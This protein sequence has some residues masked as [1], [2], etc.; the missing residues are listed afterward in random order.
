MTLKKTRKNKRLLGGDNEILKGKIFELFKENKKLHV[1]ELAKNKK[2]NYVLSA[3]KQY[4]KYIPKRVKKYIASQYGIKTDGD[5]NVS[6]LATD[7]DTTLK[8][9][10]DDKNDE[11]LFDSFYD[12]HKS[13]IENL[14]EKY[15]KDGKIENS[16]ISKIF[17]KESDF[18]KMYD[19]AFDKVESAADKGKLKTSKK[20]INEVKNNEQI[21]NILKEN[22]QQIDIDIPKEPLKSLFDEVK[23]KEKKEGK[24]KEI[25]KDD[26]KVEQV[27]EI[28]KDKEDEE[29][30]EIKGK[31]ELKRKY[32]GNDSILNKIVNSKENIKGPLFSKNLYDE[33]YATKDKP[34][35]LIQD[36]NQIKKEFNLSKNKIK[37]LED[38]IDKYSKLEVEQQSAKIEYAKFKEEKAMNN[39]I[40]MRDI[41]NM[42]GNV[43][44]NLGHAT[45]YTI[46]TARD[47][48]STIGSVGQGV[49]IKL[50]FLILIIIAIIVGI[51][52]YNDVQNANS[53]S[54]MNNNN[55]FL[56]FNGSNNFF[57]NINE[58]IGG[59]LPFSA[60]NGL[61]NSITFAMTG[62]NIYDKYLINREETT[63]GRSDNIFH[64]NYK[65]NYGDITDNEKTYCTIK[66]KDIIINYNDNN[67]PNSDYNKLDDDLK[68]D[69]NY[70]KYYHIP[71]VSNNTGKYE[72]DLKN[73]TFNNTP[74]K[75]ENIAIR[76]SLSKYNLF[77]YNNNNLVLNKFNNVYYDSKNTNTITNI[78]SVNTID[79]YSSYGIYLVN[80]NYNGINI[81]IID[82]NFKYENFN[83]TAL[84]KFDFYINNNDFNKN[85]FYVKINKKNPNYIYITSRENDENNDTSIFDF[86]DI[87]D[88]N[89]F[90]IIKLYNQ[91]EKLSVHDLYFKIPPNNNH[92]MP[93]K[94]K[95]DNENQRF[96]ID[97]IV[98]GDNSSYLY[99]D[100]AINGSINPIYEIN[101]D[102]NKLNFEDNTNCDNYFLLYPSL[103]DDILFK[104]DVTDHEL[105]DIIL[106]FQN[107]QGEQINY[108]YG[109][110]TGTKRP[111]IIRHN[112]GYINL[113]LNYLSN[114][115]YFKDTNDKMNKYIK[116]VMEKYDRNKNI[117]SDKTFISY[118]FLLYFIM[119]YFSRCQ[120][121]IN[122][123]DYNYS[124]DTKYTRLS[125][126]IYLISNNEDGGNT[127]IFGP[128]TGLGGSD[129]G[130]WTSNK[131]FRIDMTKY[132]N[133]KINS[134]FFKNKSVQSIG[135]S[136]INFKNNTQIYK[137][138]NDNKEY[139]HKELM[140]SGND[141]K[142]HLLEKNLYFREPKSFVGKLYTL[143]INKY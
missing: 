98:D 137:Y 65:N 3:A 77:K 87:Y 66:P 134:K 93:P 62:Q 28:K 90:S 138:F 136:S 52:K 143:I 19:V 59:I 43:L 127:D 69:M 108:I 117:N 9:L 60:L 12:I 45:G 114:N 68:K 85:I 71:I 105:S 128:K 95:Y 58:Y 7:I 67:Y 26:D 20:T 97:F 103:D 38:Q 112:I 24:Q 133:I 46:S 63:D 14:Y 11:E 121:Y 111:D 92:V 29:V 6:D 131:I 118:A 53:M 16:D 13:D 42:A 30:K 141:Y 10:K 124:S 50:I 84:N 79:S 80:P 33:A 94:L 78:N 22:Y 34:N 23:E 101:I 91:N 4:G 86:M 27:K 54:F 31:K 5:I 17:G 49:I 48:L 1:D 25:K 116:D 123:Y 132:P 96:Y 81:A 56:I 142:Q 122:L 21:K 89:N 110:N 37:K 61:N 39:F 83:N 115:N 100:K 113:Q 126:S 74:S 140:N 129:Y 82:V 130:E 8:Y 107:S 109:L 40:K 32:T 51:Y 2:V 99:M 35:K 57:N 47:Y 72:L 36:L 73:S 64:I 18:N 70:Y 41:A 55:K 120:F 125:Y 119:N 104:N 102:A 106:N 15:E 139:I 75:N 44:I 88:I 135:S 76:D